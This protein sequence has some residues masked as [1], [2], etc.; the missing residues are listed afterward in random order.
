M[1]PAPSDA[2]ERFLLKVSRIACLA[3]K[4]C[5]RRQSPAV[6]VRRR[7]LCGPPRQKDCEKVAR[8]YGA[9]LLGTIVYG[10]I[11]AVEISAFRRRTSC[12]DGVVL[13]I[14][15]LR[16]KACHIA[17]PMTRSTRAWVPSDWQGRRMQ[18]KPNADTSIPRRP[19][20]RY[21][22]VDPPIPLAPSRCRPGR[23]C[24]ETCSSTALSARLGRPLKSKLGGQLLRSAN[25]DMYTE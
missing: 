7:M 16:P 19:N 13:S 6:R 9:E 1:R 15:T 4:G 3:T 14:A 5:T 11:C 22:T 25:A 12:L 2:T 10:M 8:G 24:G 18:P 23:A 21:C 20:L 17:F